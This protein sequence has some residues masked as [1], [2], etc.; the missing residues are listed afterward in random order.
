MST[1]AE[2]QQWRWDTD[3][4]ARWLWRQA[5][6]VLQLWADEEGADYLNALERDREE[7]VRLRAADC[8]IA[9]LRDQI[10][11]LTQAL[12]FEGEF[13]GV[14]NI[15]EFNKL[16][17]MAAEGQKA[18]I[19]DLTQRLEARGT[20]LDE[21]AAALTAL[22]QGLEAAERN[23]DLAV[24][25]WGVGYFF[26]ASGAEVVLARYAAHKAEEGKP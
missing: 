10:A 15:E 17:R 13:K 7:L 20:L 19:A 4:E 5:G 12:Q 11:A 16:L 9:N 22:K 1:E 24:V 14:L 21:M 25:H 8:G 2:A 26:E 18:T 3:G 6:D 23:H